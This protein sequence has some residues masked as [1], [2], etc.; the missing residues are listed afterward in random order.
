MFPTLSIKLVNLWRET[1][2]SL[3]SPFGI[4]LHPF[5]IGKKSEVWAD[6]NQII[7][8]L[9]CCTSFGCQ[10]KEARMENCGA[11]R[12][13]PFISPFLPLLTGAYISP[14]PGSMCGERAEEWNTH[15]YTFRKILKNYMWYSFLQFIWSSP[16]KR[17]Y[18]VVNNVTVWKVLL[19]LK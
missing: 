10:A 14:I 9:Q 11:W 6:L 5:H 15:K 1:V 16:F 19:K 3:R 17:C 13:C 8:M 7:E 4:S 2:K 12:G 18:F